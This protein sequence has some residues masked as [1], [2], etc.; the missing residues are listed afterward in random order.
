LRDVF[1]T[2]RDKEDIVGEVVYS[3]GVIM[4]IQYVSLVILKW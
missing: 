2:H 3:Q 4:L 1:K